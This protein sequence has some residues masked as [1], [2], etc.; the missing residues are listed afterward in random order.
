MESHGYRVS[1]LQLL[2]PTRVL[3][4]VFFYG[5][6]QTVQLGSQNLPLGPSPQDHLL[7]V[8]GLPFF[9]ES[10]PPVP[11][12]AFVAEGILLQTQAPI[13]G[14]WLYQGQW[15]LLSGP[16]GAGSSLEVTPQP[17]PPPPGFQGPQGNE[18]L[19]ELASQGPKPF[20]LLAVNPP[21]PPLSFTP[22]PSKLEVH[23]YAVEYGVHLQ[24]LLA[25]QA[26]V[27]Q[28][29][30]E[31]AYH[32]S[33]PAAYLIHNQAQLNQLWGLVSGD[34]FPPPPP[35]SIDFQSGSLLLIFQ[36]QKPT[37]GYGLKFLGLEPTAYGLE[38][39]VEFQS[40]PRGAM[41][42]Q[43]LTSPYLLLYLPGQPQQVQVV[44]P[45]GLQLPAQTP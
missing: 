30:G 35:P 20:L 22:T 43:I 27:L 40:P 18:A 11:F 13:Q 9:S 44:S 32:G 4:L 8:Q 39:L 29:G 10:A 6:P 3:Q 17:S 19:S 45:D 26:R 28:A 31:S 23:A 7:L 15:Y 41:V 25:A 12:P 2:L 33:L 36:G 1:E 16:V 24:S 38:V 5:T 21:L 14:A 37:G 42:P 34:R